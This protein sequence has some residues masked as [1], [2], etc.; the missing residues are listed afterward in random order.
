MN[1]LFKKKG[2]VTATLA[3]VLVLLASSR[4]TIFANGSIAGIYI[5]YI[6]ISVDCTRGRLNLACTLQ[7]SNSTLIHYPSPVDLSDIHLVN[8]TSI[9]ATFSKTDSTLLFQFNDTSEA[10]AKDNADAVISSM[11]T[12]F[13]LTFTYNSSSLISL[14][15]PIRS[16]HIQSRRED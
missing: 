5:E 7:S 13:D 9:I 3:A 4:Q 1:H 8:C 2:L 12:A 14:P 6:T 10:V 11:N 16:S 15:Y